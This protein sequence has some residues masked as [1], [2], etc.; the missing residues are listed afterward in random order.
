MRRSLIVIGA[1]LAGLGTGCGE[2]A[3]KD[4][5]KT[6]QTVD[7]TPAR[8]IAFPDKFR[9]VATKCDGFGHRIYSNSTGDSGTGA[10]LFVINDP[11]CNKE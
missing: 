1:I 7:R 5:N 10:E 9:N 11:R 4:A 6:G 8:V 2:E 3:T